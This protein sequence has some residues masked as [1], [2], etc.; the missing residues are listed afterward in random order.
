M[1]ISVSKA[2]ESNLT[3]DKN[4]NGD[5]LGRKYTR[6]AYSDTWHSETFSSR[7]FIS[8]FLCF[9]K[10]DRTVSNAQTSDFQPQL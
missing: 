3:P 1:R 6:S 5:Y 2:E 9:K 7:D 10:F 4:E 8:F